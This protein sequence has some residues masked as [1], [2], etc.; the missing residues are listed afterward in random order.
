MVGIDKI[1]NVKPK[2]KFKTIIPEQYWGYLKVFDENETNQLPS[3][4]GRKI[5][6]AIELLEKGKK[7]NGL[8]G[9]VIQYLKRR[10]SGIE[11]IT[12]R[13]FE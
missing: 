6:H 2:L 1:L 12:D 9:A 7:T 10:T 8:L 11:E 3:S 4:R 5:N 13:I